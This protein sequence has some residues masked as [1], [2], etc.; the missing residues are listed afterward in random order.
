MCN[1]FHTHVYIDV[2]LM[3]YVD[4]YGLDITSDCRTLLEIVASLPRHHW[5]FSI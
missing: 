3:T 5:K 1:I 4:L 2:S